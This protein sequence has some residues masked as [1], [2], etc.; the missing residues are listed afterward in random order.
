MPFDGPPLALSVTPL[1]ETLARM[2][3]KPIERCVLD[4]H[5]AAQIRRYPESWGYTHRHTL[6]VAL[7]VTLN[8]LL[9]GFFFSLIGAIL[10]DILGS[11]ACLSVSLLSAVGIVLIFCNLVKFVPRI[12][13]RKP[14]RWNVRLLPMGAPVAYRLPEMPTPIAELV[15]TIKT[16][17]NHIGLI[18][19]ELRRDTEILDPFIGVRDLNSGE[20][21][22]LGIWDGATILHI[23]S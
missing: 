11:S 4:A 17:N 22:I 15:A 21:A 16:Q 5:M 7:I 8:I 12:K 18:Y 14:A 9:I 20:E 6:R 13:L 3:I 10:A 2:G 23:A 19:G 1:A